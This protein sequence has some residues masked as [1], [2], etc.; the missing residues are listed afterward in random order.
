MKNKMPLQFLLILLG[1]FLLAGTASTEETTPAATI[2]FNWGL[3]HQDKNGVQKILDFSSSPE[4]ATGDSL[5]IYV[6]PLENVYVYLYLFDSSKDI[7]LVFPESPDFYEQQPSFLG[8]E[9][10][11]PSSETWFDIVDPTGIENFYLLAASERLISLEKATAKYMNDEG[12]A[13]LRATLLEEIKQIRQSHSNFTKIA[14]KGISIAGTM[15]TRAIS[16]IGEATM[17]EAETFYS[18]TLRLK[19]D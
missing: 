18:K 2:R 9:F 5:R 6:R 10:Y 7:A 12:N 8:N 4:I 19:H 3:I 16:T 15:R 17:V 13:E 1:I 14:E 11:I